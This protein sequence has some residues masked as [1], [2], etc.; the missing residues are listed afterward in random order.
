[1]AHE[2]M[3]IVTGC[4]TPEQFVGMFHRFC[5]AKTCFIPTRDTRPVGT[6]LAFSL[7][8]VDGTPMLR[9]NCVV[10][11]PSDDRM[12]PYQR[13][14]VVLGIDTLSPD[15]EALFEMLLAQKTQVG[16]DGV[17]EEVKRRDTN[18]H[19]PR[20]RVLDL[21]FRQGNAPKFSETEKD[22]IEMPP[23]FNDCELTNDD[24]IPEPTEPAETEKVDARETRTLLGMP[25]VIA[26]A[27][28][29]PE[30]ID[31]GADMRRESIEPPPAPRLVARTR[32][33]ELVPRPPARIRSTMVLRAMSVD[34][35]FWY[36][37]ALGAG[38]FVTALVLM[39][40]YIAGV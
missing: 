34:E 16:S 37:C 14:G 12:N 19:V 22:T 23:L 9:G 13:P 7:R 40:A 3:R 33:L 10:K 29:T 25:P 15:S 11:A 24:A 27:T 26:A 31:A 4:K 35:R 21:L 30:P 17:V 2:A 36:L 1:M 39:S 20:N 5:D 38:L 8:L 18:Q 32:R 28:R 6:E